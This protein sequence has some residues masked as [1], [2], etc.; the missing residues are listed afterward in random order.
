[1]T[2][3]GS[4]LR[5]VIGMKEGSAQPKVAP[6]VKVR[7]LAPFSVPGYA[8]YR[9]GDL[10]APMASVAEVWA[11]QGRVLITT[12]CV[13]TAIARFGFEAAQCRDWNPDPDLPLAA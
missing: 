5:K 7:V 9:R 2:T 10:I 1:M 6:R 8:N 3:I 12:D 4:K 11:S 13:E